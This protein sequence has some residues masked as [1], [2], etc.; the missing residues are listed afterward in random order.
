MCKPVI[1]LVQDKL[2]HIFWNAHHI[3]TVHNHHGEHHAEEDIAKA[4]QDEQD[5]KIC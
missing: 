1:P 2:A 5:N 3:A 4:T